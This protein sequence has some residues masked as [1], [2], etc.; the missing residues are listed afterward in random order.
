[1]MIGGM[2]RTGRTTEV[3]MIKIDLQGHSRMW[4]TDVAAKSTKSVE[5]KTALL[6]RGHRHRTPS[7]QHPPSHLGHIEASLLSFTSYSP[8]S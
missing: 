1:M 8:I 7:K 5:E 3:E 2:N 6:S 4:R